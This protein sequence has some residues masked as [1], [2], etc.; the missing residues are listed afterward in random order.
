MSRDS[1]LGLIVRRRQLLRRPGLHGARSA[2]R[3]IGQGAER[4]HRVRADRH[5]HRAQP[6]RLLPRQ[7]HDL[8]A[9]GVREARRDRCR[10][11]EPAAATSTP[12]TSRASTRMRVQLRNPD[13]HVVLPE[14]ISKEPLGPSVRQGDDQWFTARQVGATT[15]CSTPRSSA[16]RKPTSMRCSS[17]P[18]PTSSACSAT[19]ASS[20][21]PSASTTTGSSRS[22]R[23]SATTARCYERNVGP[24]S[25]LK[26]ARGLNN[27]WNK[28]GIQYAPPIR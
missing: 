26:I 3:E 7:Q 15:R 28:G 23:R 4:R 13:D 21:R 22:S 5:H 24:D 27:L 9:G 14:I 18:I 10:P 17:R 11:I 19:R 12:P 16:S 8:Q 6:R 1:S 20:A 25:R 2:R